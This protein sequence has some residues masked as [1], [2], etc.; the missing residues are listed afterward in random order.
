[1]KVKAN[2]AK[3]TECLLCTTEVPDSYKLKKVLGMAWGSEVKSRGA[4][5]NLVAFLRSFK[6]G[7]VPELQNMAQ[8]ARKI[9]VQRMIEAAKK[10][11]ANGVVGVDLTGF[12]F[13]N[14]VIEFISYG[15]AVV[16][17]KKG[18]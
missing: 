8:E 14:D 2:M 12:T 4:S 16:V 11:G 7:N 13:K 5:A 10:M 3:E 17:E 9:S 18:K 1:M 6:G 15:T